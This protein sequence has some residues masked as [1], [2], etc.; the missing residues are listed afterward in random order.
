MNELSIICRL[1]VRSCLRDADAILL[2]VDA[3]SN[4]TIADS[5]TERFSFVDM[6][7]MDVGLYYVFASIV[8]I[9]SAKFPSPLLLH[10]IRLI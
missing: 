10:L 5:W 1:K 3:N 9:V 7:Y 4:L 6:Y 2:V 8:M